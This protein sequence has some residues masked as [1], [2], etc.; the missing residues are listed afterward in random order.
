[1]VGV[2]GGAPAENV[3][4]RLGDVV[5]SKPARNTGSVIQYDSGKL[6]AGGIFNQTGSL[7]S[8][9]PEVLTTLSTM[10]AKHLTHPTSFARYISNLPSQF[11]SPGSE[12]DRLFDWSYDHVGGE[13]CEACDETKVVRR[14]SRASH[15]PIPH[16]GIIA[17]GSQVMKD[18]RTRERLRKE[19]GIICFETEAAGL[20]NRFQSVVIRGISDYSDSHKNGTWKHYAAATAAA[21]AKEFLVT[22]SSH[23]GSG[24]DSSSATVLAPQS[25]CVIFPHLLPSTAVGLGWLC[26]NTQAPWIDFCPLKPDLKDGDVITVPST[27][28][29]DLVRNSSL[30]DKF[31]NLFTREGT[32]TISVSQET[33]QVLVNSGQVFR[34][35]S[36]E[37]ETKK[38][39]QRVFKYGCKAY[40][41]V[42]KHIIVGYSG[43]ADVLLALQFCRIKFRSRSTAGLDSALMANDTLKWNPIVVKSGR[44]D[45]GNGETLEAALQ[46]TFC[47]EDLEEQYKADAF[48]VDDQVTII[49]ES[50]K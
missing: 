12:K 11:S 24:T 7:N 28:I 41:I 43:A 29:R 22:L 2:A 36:Q 19:Y 4:I 26:I 21:Y 23:D 5:V 14:I 3:D 13:A 48:L 35:L 33:I 49:S 9:S 40:M 38:W 50:R 27:R 31:R 16:Y 17:S 37:D 45:E 39:L 1:M 32:R 8:P 25:S 30:F 6:L 47:A 18:G 42:G 44:G 20:M 34:N 10:Q 15:L 46:E